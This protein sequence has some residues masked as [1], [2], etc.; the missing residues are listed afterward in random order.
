MAKAKR[1]RRH[2][3]RSNPALQLTRWSAV[4]ASEAKQPSFS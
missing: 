3:E 1:H 4:M 2:C